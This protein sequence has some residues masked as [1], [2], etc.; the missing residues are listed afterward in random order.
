MSRGFFN[1]FVF[2][3]TF[4]EV[5]EVK[6]L[7]DFNCFIVFKRQSLN[8]IV[9]SLKEGFLCLDAS[10]NLIHHPE[11][12]VTDLFFIHFC[13]GCRKRKGSRLTN[14]RGA[15]PN[16]QALFL[17]CGELKALFASRNRGRYSYRAIYQIP[18]SI[19]GICARPEFG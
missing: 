5:C 14:Q 8:Q 15:A 19:L 3:V 2:E 11:S 6:M 12:I 4:K 9:A 16:L 1:L 13:V 10:G 7:F 17:S 18:K